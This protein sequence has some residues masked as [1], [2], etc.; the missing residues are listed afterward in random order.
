MESFDLVEVLLDLIWV[1]HLGMVGEGKD[2]FDLVEILVR[3][4]LSWLS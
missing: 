1:S 3:I 2:N 4:D